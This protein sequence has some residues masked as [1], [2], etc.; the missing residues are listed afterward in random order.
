MGHLLPWWLPRLR[1]LLP[2]RQQRYLRSQAAGRTPSPKDDTVRRT[3]LVIASDGL[4]AARSR[5]A[6]P[7]ST[8]VWNAW[9][10]SQ[11][12]FSSFC[13]LHC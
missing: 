7:G 10:R 5:R 6:E 4:S 3:I 13:T 12:T 2:C 8:D 9:T 11:T 1:D